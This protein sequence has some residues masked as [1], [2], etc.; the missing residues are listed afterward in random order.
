MD[1]PIY[2]IGKLIQWKW[3]NTHLSEDKFVLMLGALHIEFV[4]EAMK[5][6]MTE[7]TGMAYLACQAGIL[8]SGRA[9][10]FSSHPDHHLKRTRYMHQVFLLVLAMLKNEAYSLEGSGSQESWEEAMK[11]KS[12]MFAYWCMV[13]DMEFLH[14]QF[15]RSLREG[16]FTLY[17]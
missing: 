4:I 6:K 9:E 5:A 7:G 11:V 16:D 8:T 13:M 2:A 17:V 1:Q 3:R 15:V 12:K 10:S 14:C